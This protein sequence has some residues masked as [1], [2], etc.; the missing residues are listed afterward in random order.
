MGDGGGNSLLFTTLEEGK[1]Q[2]KIENFL[3][4][5]RTRV[6]V[7][8][9]VR[10]KKITKYE[11]VDSVGEIIYTL[12]PKENFYMHIRYTQGGNFM[13]SG[14][15]AKR[16]VYWYVLKKFI[17]GA[18]L[19]EYKNGLQEPVIGTPDYS[20]LT[21]LVN[22]MS[23]DQVDGKTKKNYLTDPIKF[24]TKQSVLDDEILKSVTGRARLSNMLLKLKMPYNFKKIGRNNQNMQS[25]PL[26][27]L[28]DIQMGY[29]MRTSKGVLNT[30]DSKYANA[31][32]EKDN[33]QNF[34]LD[35]LKS[36]I[37]KI[38]E[39]FFLPTIDPDYDSSV[40]ELRFGRDPDS[41]DI[42]IFNARTTRLQATTTT[43]TQL[44][45]VP[46]AI[47][48]PFTY[49]FETNEIIP[50]DP[51][52]AKAKEIKVD[53]EKVEATD[54]E[55]RSSGK[56]KKLFRATTITDEVLETN[57]ATKFNDLIRKSVKKQLLDYTEKL[58]KRANLEDAIDNLDEDLV[59]I[60]YFGL[61]ISVYKDQLI[62]FS[63]FGIQDWVDTVFTPTTRQAKAPYPEIPY[64]V[65]EDVLEILDIKS[66]IIIKGAENVS[67]EKLLRVQ[68]IFGRDIKNYAGMDTT[69]TH[70]INTILRNVLEDAIGLDTIRDDIK[71]LIQTNDEEKILKGL[72]KLRQ[73]I[74]QKGV[75]KLDLLPDIEKI[76]NQV[77]GDLISPDIQ[78]SLIELVDDLENQK[79]TKYDVRKAID[80]IVKHVDNIST[81]RA[82]TIAG[83]EISQ[84]IEATRFEM[85]KGE[86]YNEKR[87]F[88]VGDE[89]VRESHRLNGEQG[90]INI[91]TSFSNGAITPAEEY[92]CRCT[93]AFRRGEVKQVYVNQDPLSNQ[94]DNI[95]KLP[96]ED[97]KGAISTLLNSLD[98]TEPLYGAVKKM[99]QLYGITVK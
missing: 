16:A 91:D 30:M 26:L 23:T 77:P 15:P 11:V 43:L 64:V 41:E 52:S 18:N 59:A 79:K 6:R 84:A 83:T 74:D 72:E 62:K 42:E 54:T 85:Y 12:R 57:D 93:L 46:S 27:K 81:N 58:E 61:N 80:I 82:N 89:L 34:V 29:A 68:K 37:E 60:N 3:D 70:Q 28:C 51:K 9:D 39:E 10:K 88:T 75:K 56:K 98:G 47:I 35:P 31:E 63:R 53:E 7:Y 48:P 36:R 40:Y 4:D 38:G 21:H 66:E 49:D 78:K 45:H 14:N 2:F 8:G 99:A 95:F 87:W 94:M 22:V 17:A 67:E 50:L 86:D 90:W 44:S 25:I 73:K 69:T 97:Q 20:A 65:P 96:K 1:I 13:F 32:I 24:L 5:G 76:Y 19:A 55:E 92:N 33:W 71:A